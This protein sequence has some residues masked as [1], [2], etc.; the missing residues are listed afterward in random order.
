MA[1]S[2]PIHVTFLVRPAPSLDSFVD[3]LFIFDVCIQL[4]SGYMDRGFPVLELRY[5][6]KRYAR[7]WMPLDMIASVPYERLYLL[8]I[9]ESPLDFTAS[10]WLTL[11]S[12]LKIIR[13]V[14]LSRLLTAFELLSSKSFRVFL[15]LGS[16]VLL[17]HW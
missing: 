15:S 10:R 2:V 12:C 16:W 7:T 14:R 3:F 1:V 9:G 8:S 13:F 11:A 5:V 6:T 4:I 17:G